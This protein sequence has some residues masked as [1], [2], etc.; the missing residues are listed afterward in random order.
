MIL[1]L[2]N[3]DSFTYN[4]F[5]ALAG[6][7]EKVRILRNDQVTLE[8]IAAMRPKAMVISPGPGTPDDAG[9][10]KAA[11]RRFAGRIPILG[12]CLGHQVI[13]EVFGGRVIRAPEP[14]H[15]KVSLVSHRGTGL[16]QKVSDP[17]SAGRYHSLIVDRTR[18]PACLEITATT[19]DGLIMGLSHRD[20]AVE[21]LQFHP[22]SIL[23][24][25]GKRILGNFVA[26]INGQGCKI[27]QTLGVTT[28]GKA[29]TRTEESL[30]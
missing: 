23:T 11:V 28:P 8:E 12:I 14:V 4:V 5:Q 22:E 18:L 13:G 25:D 26:A 24:P 30:C 6:M 16:F 27:P 9:I 21:G 17:F 15:G 19:P 29:G 3:Y 2:D 20:Y 10:S 1:L 7:G